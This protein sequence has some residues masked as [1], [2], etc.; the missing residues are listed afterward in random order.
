MQP[1]AFTIDD[2]SGHYLVEQ[3]VSEKDI[4]I[5]ANHLARQGTKKGEVITSPDKT[6]TYLQTI[7]QKLE[8]EV[9]GV[10]CLDQQHRILHYEELFKGS[11]SSA[12]VYPR[13]IVKLALQHN[14]AA[15]IL[16]HNHPSG[17]PQPSQSDKDITKQI[18]QALEL[19]EVRTLD[20]VIVGKEGY[21][22]L[23]EQHNL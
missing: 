18:K 1:T 10:I 7:L 22:S 23:A 16:F 21:I 6:Y 2:E 9:F 8:H 14:T 19:I 11:I 4:L 15:V 13:E 3:V 5:M 17:N 12:Q 20:H